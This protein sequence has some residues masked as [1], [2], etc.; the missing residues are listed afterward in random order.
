M[1][2]RL[3]LRSS[4][5]DKFKDFEGRFLGEWVVGR[6]MDGFGFG[7]WVG[8]MTWRIDCRAGGARGEVGTYDS[9]KCYEQ[10]F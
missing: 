6:L 3:I 2:G 7:V 8:Y 10:R 1:A 5:P 4:L 9:I